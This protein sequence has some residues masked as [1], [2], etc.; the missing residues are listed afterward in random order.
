MPESTT[1]RHLV[2]HGHFYQPPRENPWTERID[3]Q[4]GAAPY[5]DWNEKIAAEC[6]VP[7]T[8]SRRL[9]GYGRITRLVNNYEWISFNF[10]P[11]LLSWL[12]EK[13]PGTYQRILDADRLSAARTGGHGNAIAQAYNH[14]IMPL[15][16][17]RDQETQIRWGVRDFEQRFGREPEGIWLPETAINGTTLK[18]LIDFGFRFIILSPHQADRIHPLQKGGRWKNV[19]DGSIP[20]GSPYRCFDRDQKCRRDTRRFI[21]VFFYDAPLSV[22]VS[23][24]H[25]LRN[26]DRF[27]ESIAAAY[28]RNGGDLVAVATDGEIYGHHEPFADMALSYLADTA[29]PARNLSLTNFGA[30]LD[31]HEPEWEVRLKDGDKGEG[32]A[33]SCAHGVGRWK[34]DCGC[35]VGAPPE[36]NQKWRKPLRRGLNGLRDELSALF[37][38]EGSPLLEDPWTARNDYF[39]VIADRSVEN[40]ERFL[41]EHAVRTI[42]PEERS[43]ALALLESQRF[44]L[45]MFTSC[46]W[47]FNDISGI[48]SVQLFRYAARAIELAGTEHKERLEKLLLGE[49]SSANSNA[50]DQGTGSD[51]YTRAVEAVSTD[52]P[53]VA[54]QHAIFS[55][56]FGADE[57]SRA[58]AYTV[59]TIDRIERSAGGSSVSVGCVEIISPYTLER[60]MYRYTV[61]VEDGAAVTCCVGAVA[62]PG[63]FRETA[64]RLREM[65][66]ERL[67]ADPTLIAG[68]LISGRCITLKD[69]FLEDRERILLHICKDILETVTDRYEKLY[70][71]NRRLLSLLKEA[72]ITPPLS[73][74]VP[75]QAVL[76]RK[77]IR[78]VE[79]WQHTL[80]PAGLDG[81]KGVVSEAEAHGVEIDTTA[82]SL[83]FRDLVLETTVQFEERLDAGAA[84]ALLQFVELSHTLG[85]GIEMHDIQNEIYHVLETTVMREIELLRAAAGVEMEPRVGVDTAPESGSG[86]GTARGRRRAVEAFLTIARRFNFNTDSYEERLP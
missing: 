21:D 8:C 33:W 3:R 23:F 51:I 22:D 84:D 19:Q 25:L 83:V 31:G 30:Y 38:R 9:D 71:E 80:E 53:F 34:E 60:Y 41:S 48:E 70:D 27:A 54:G 20:A 37:E 55:H 66:E 63:A 77:L 42:S 68:E 12:E 82:A 52:M 6:Y 39:A 45:L 32:T 64:E 75:A 76:T 7:N 36:W 10:G 69:L 57:I 28:Q 74:I 40:A 44:A 58:F 46:G 16:A 86:P 73:L 14:I 17:V 4:A 5:H 85:I 29:A 2:I 56:F 50:P 13:H 72:A 18:I 26:G 15:A 47:F 24:N 35:N 62:E 78:E 43:R 67:A 61:A 11:T 49:L 65:P 1:L 59:R 79:R 81:I